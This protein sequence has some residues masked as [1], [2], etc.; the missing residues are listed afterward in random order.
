MISAAWIQ[1]IRDA[2]EAEKQEEQAKSPVIVGYSLELFKG[3]KTELQEQLSSAPQFKLKEL[4]DAGYAMTHLEYLE[5]S[6]SGSL[7]QSLLVLER[8]EQKNEGA[9]FRNRDLIY[10]FD[11]KQRLISRGAIFSMNPSSLTLLLDDADP[12]EVTGPFIVTKAGSDATYRYNQQVLK[13]LQADTCIGEAGRYFIQMFFNAENEVRNTQKLEPITCN[14]N[15]Q[16][17]KAV[18]KMQ[19]MNPKQYLVVHGPP[20][21]GK[22]TTV[23]AGIKAFIKSNPSARVLITG[24]S[25]VSVDNVMMQLNGLPM[26]RIGSV[27][28][29]SEE[30]T[31][32]LLDNVVQRLNQSE[33]NGALIDVKDAK[34]GLQ[35]AKKKQANQGDK[36]E[37]LQAKQNLRAMNKQLQK[38]E[39]SCVTKTLQQAKIICCTLSGCSHF[40]TLVAAEYSKGFDLVVI[41]EAAQALDV[42]LISALYL[43][44]KAVVFAG[45]PMQ[46]A[47]TV[48]SSSAPKEYSEP[49]L[50]RLC[51]QNEKVM[52]SDNYV[53]LDTQYR[54]DKLINEFPSK[55]FY[56]SR[57]KANK[58]E[59]SQTLEWT[60]VCFLNTAGYDFVEEKPDS[61]KIFEQLSLRNQNEAELVVKLVTKLIDEGE[62]PNNIGVIS[63]Y[64][65]QISLLNQQLGGQGIE[66]ATVD[67][68][69]GREKEIII[70][71]MVRSNDDGIVGFMN[72]PRRLNVSITRAK[73]LLIVVGDA[74]TLQ[75]DKLLGQYVDWLYDNADQIAVDEI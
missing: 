43:A 38:A 1:K 52:E 68:F 64:A 45:D 19:T 29:A 18:Q 2:L 14:L 71:S 62:S 63:G 57:L 34:L 31:P 60:S 7:N 13:A 32:Y 9:N 54:F 47:P 39:Q 42:Q 12:D 20:G 35:K 27:A 11:H 66:I 22:T 69:Q 10:L 16:Q 72:D 51:K 24:P 73:R 28:R 33:L 4:Q 55:Q 49:L 50:Y 5:T 75:K 65:A 53:L 3:N 61:G 15:E 48:L 41:D 59:V 74:E 23:S 6:S 44:K 56:N 30:I 21:S 67:G 17:Q 36:K 8:P 58:Q 46:L 70:M 37:F 25:N 40:N 26:V